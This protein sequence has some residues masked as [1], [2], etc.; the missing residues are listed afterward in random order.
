MYRRL[1]AGA[2]DSYAVYAR[3]GLADGDETRA[4]ARDALEELTQALALSRQLGDRIAEAHAL[5]TL[6]FARGRR[7]ASVRVALSRGAQSERA[8]PLT[9]LARPGAWRPNALR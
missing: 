7:A 2:S 1:I 3:L 6:A 5:L 4:L 8:G 9:D